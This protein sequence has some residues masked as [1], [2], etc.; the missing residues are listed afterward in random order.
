ART[1]IIGH[2]D[3]P[4]S[5]GRD[6]LGSD[7]TVVDPTVDRRDCEPEHVSCLLHSDKLAAIGVRALASGDLPVR[8]QAA[9]ATRGEAHAS[10][11]CAALAIEDARDGVVGVVTR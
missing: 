7:E 3:L 2:T 5:S 10:G 1:Q 6:L 11:R 4:W 8:A 9:D